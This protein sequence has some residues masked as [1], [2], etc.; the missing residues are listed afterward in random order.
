MTA[1]EAQLFIENGQLKKIYYFI[2]FL[3]NNLGYK[4]KFYKFL[5][6]HVYIW[7]KNNILVF[8]AYRL[9]NELDFANFAWLIWRRV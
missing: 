7:K 2:I 3:Y 1:V 9:A 4:S 5:T 6:W 8:G